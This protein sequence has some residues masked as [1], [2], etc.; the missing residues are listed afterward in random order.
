MQS[1]EV[2]K[3][4]DF[5]TSERLREYISRIVVRWYITDGHELLSDDVADEVITDVDMFVKYYGAS[6]RASDFGYECAYP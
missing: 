1:D 5:L 6:E 4:F 2:R 3:R